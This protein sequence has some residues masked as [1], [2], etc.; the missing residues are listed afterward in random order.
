MPPV[1]PPRST[2]RRGRPTWADRSATTAVTRSQS[3]AV[4]GE[5][6]SVPRR[7]R[8]S[9]GI[10]APSSLVVVSHTLVP[11]TARAGVPQLPRRG[12]RAAS[13]SVGGSGPTPAAAARPWPERTCSPGGSHV[14]VR[15]LP[16]PRRVHQH[17]ADAAPPAGRSAAHPAGPAGL[18]GPV[19][20]GA[21]RRH[22]AHRGPRARP[23][24]PRAQAPGSAPDGWTGTGRHRRGRSRRT[25]GRG[26]SRAPPR[27]PRPPRSA[28]GRASPDSSHAPVARSDTPRGPVRRT[29]PRTSSSQEWKTVAA[30]GPWTSS[31]NVASTGPV[32]S[33]RVRKTTR[34]PD[35]IGGV[36]VATLTP[37]TRISLRLRARRSQCRARTAP[38]SASMAA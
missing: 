13:R 34:R 8:E 5:W 36:W 33:S 30:Y 26:S 38:R 6:A 20:A 7:R 24:P 37:A 9:S 18:G 1:P 19:G 27:R 15:R 25:P 23:P 10:D 11:R 14:G 31:K 35:R 4:R 17:S 3:T 2:T 21:G 12:R 16:E 32:A 22:R 29:T 28:T